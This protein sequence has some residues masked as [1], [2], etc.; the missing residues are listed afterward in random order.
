[1]RG[2]ILRPGFS[3]FRHRYLRTIVAIR[4]SL[5]PVLWKREEEFLDGGALL[6]SWKLSFRR[7]S[8]FVGE[9]CFSIIDSKYAS[10]GFYFGASLNFYFWSSVVIVIRAD[11][12]GSYIKLT[13][14]FVLW[15]LYLSFNIF[16]LVEFLYSLTMKSLYNSFINFESLYYEL[17]PLSFKQ[18]YIY[19][20]RFFN[21]SF[22]AYLTY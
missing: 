2:F 12:K 20:Y 16:F 8:C 19:N 7:I 9:S 4:V 17:I 18:I 15:I 5:L 1:M 3:I 14:L 13:M 6:F 21:Y 22:H 10:K 11:L